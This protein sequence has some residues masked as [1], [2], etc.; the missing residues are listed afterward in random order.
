MCENDSLTLMC[1][2]A[3]LFQ[4]ESLMSLGIVILEYARGIREEKNPLMG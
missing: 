3:P 1:P 2:H 4:N